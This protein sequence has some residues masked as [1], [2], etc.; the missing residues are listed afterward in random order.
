V[1][2][3]ADDAATVNLGE[4]WRTPTY[5]DFMELIDNSDYSY[6]YEQGLATFTS[7]INGKS[8][9][10]PNVG[11]RYRSGK[12]SSN[13]LMSANITG[14]STS[15]Y[16]NYPTMFNGLYV[17]LVD[18]YMNVQ[19]LDDGSRLFGYNIRPVSGGTRQGIPL[20]AHVGESY[21]STSNTITFIPQF[22]NEEKAGWT[23][24]YRAFL[25]QNGATGSAW[26]IKT[27]DSRSASVTFDGL[28]SGTTYYYSIGWAGSGNSTAETGESEVR[29]ASTL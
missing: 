16:G 27:L 5:Y 2:E 19:G 6:D 17:L 4:E 20:T 24:T 26:K 1:L 8:I 22:L 11:H 3:A 12:E 23:Y 9:V 15:G 25:Y 29:A 10:I 28:E 18:S 21:S 14:C 13:Y 7:R